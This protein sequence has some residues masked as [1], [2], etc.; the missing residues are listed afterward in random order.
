M[1]ERRFVVM[2]VGGTT[3]RTGLYR[4]E[5]D[6]LEAVRR[7]P[8]SGIAIDPDTPVRVLQE[9][10]I[11]QIAAE[12]ETALRRH[13]GSAAGIAFAGPV[14]DAGCVLGAPTIWGAGGDPVAAADLLRERL[15]VPVVVVNDVAAAV[16]RYVRGPEEPP[17]CLI[18]VSSGIGNKV[19]WGGRVLLDGGHGGELGHWTWRTDPAAPRCDC[20]GRGHLG[21]IASGRGLL[22]AARAAGEADAPAY[23]ASALGLACP[24]PDQ[25]TNEILALAIRSRDPFATGVLRAGLR[26]LASAITSVFC[27]IGVRRFRIIGGFAR[28]VGQRYADLLTECLHEN[29]CFGL[30]PADID[31]LVLMGH[32]DDDHGLIGA[33]RL[34]ARETGN[35]YGSGHIPA[36]DTGD[37]RNT[38]HVLAH[39][40]GSLAGERA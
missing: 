20:G 39:D 24:R 19:Y 33:G 30:D 7:T 35:A 8:T 15:G 11:G 38:S 1:A 25:L 26:P 5:G 16:W 23:R 21:A 37:V 36:G 9:R 13:G 31:R 40:S 34:L 29:D 2:D 12:A 17:F 4:P 32:A 6:T 27:A 10:V 14:T 18:T 28:A 22:A 3:L